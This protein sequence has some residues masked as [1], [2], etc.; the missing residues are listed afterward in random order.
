LTSEASLAAS[1]LVAERRPVAHGLGAALGELVG[2]PEAFMAALAEGLASL[3]DDGYAAEQER[4][5]PGSGVT[6]GVRW[7]L[8]HAIE[9]ALRPALRRSSTGPVLSL[10][11]RLAR[12][13]AREVRL[14]ALP[15]LR[16]T[17]PDDP[18]RSWQLM[19]RLAAGASDWIS[20]DSL[21]DVY[22]QGVIAEGFRWAE[23]E[24]LAYSSRRM[25]RRLVGSTLARIPHALPP[26]ERS[27]LD[28]GPA[29]ALVEDLIGDADDQVQ[30]ALSW[31]LREWT[32]VDPTAVEAYLWAEAE[33]ARATDDGH[34]AWVIR[35]AVA[36]LP[37]AT[38]ERLRASVAGI[39]KRPH[40][41]SASRAQQVATAFAVGALA[42]R[43]VAQQGDRFAGRGS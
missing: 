2:D 13:E 20:V 36:N 17:L 21:A 40:A 11:Q 5:A 34:R 10:A 31:S 39:R 12:A 32:R 37:P 30:K 16:R 18:E 19:R 29:L 26:R 41:P 35:D 8:V 33:R 14:M 23:L 9:T 28:A 24:Q 43:A 7:P 4:I 3:A 42:D 27:E 22:A 38:A 1:A 6:I 15:C 25:E